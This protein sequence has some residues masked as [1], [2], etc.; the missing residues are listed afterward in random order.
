[1]STATP[2]LPTSAPNPASARGGRPYLITAETYSKMLAAGAIPDANRVELWEGQI[3][4]KM[5]KNPPHSAA[6]KTLNHLLVR[7]LPDGWHVAPECPLRL[8]PLHVPEPDLTIVR[9][10]PHDY[11]DRDPTPADVGLVVEV[12]DSSVPKNLGRMR[13]AY[14]A[15]GV[16]NYWVLNLRTRRVE[17]HAEPVNGDTPGYLQIRSYAPDESVP[18]ILDGQ[19]IAELLVSSLLPEEQKF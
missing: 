5:G 6:L 16:S 2:S 19:S 12:A 11:L 15:G 7:L 4:E 10:D 18:L 17:T 9:G 1:M 8:S 3:V 14:A 13:A